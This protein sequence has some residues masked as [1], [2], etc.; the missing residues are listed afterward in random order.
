[1]CYSHFLISPAYCKK[2]LEKETTNMNTISLQEE[3]RDIEQLSDLELAEYLL[4]HKEE[5]DII[6]SIF[7]LLPMNC[8][9]RCLLEPQNLDALITRFHADCD[10][11]VYILTTIISLVR[12]AGSKETTD[13]QILVNDICKY[14]QEHANEEVAIEQIAK[15]M[16]VSFYY[17]CHLFKNMTNTTITTYRNQCRINK[18]KLMLHSTDKKITSI[19]IE[20]GFNNASYFTEVFTKTTGISPSNYRATKGDALYMPYYDD[21]D[22][23]LARMLPFRK[24]MS[25]NSS[26]A[27]TANHQ[28]K[29]YAVA[30]PTE[31]YRFL[32]ETAIIEYH[33]ILFASWYNNPVDELHGRTPIRGS[34][35]N[36]GGKTWR[37]I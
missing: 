25:D 26:A 20:C 10:D 8:M 24:L 17:M 7:N 3:T 4:F 18:A 37:D 32:H 30:T 2:T 27:L 22:K 28:M 23:A 36:D 33:G 31:E 16:H 6:A 5:K 11:K 15:D 21:A 29:T 19:A 34:R 9:D 1:M 13:K 12:S 14:I 35:S